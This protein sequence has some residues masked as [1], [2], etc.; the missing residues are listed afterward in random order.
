[1]DMGKLELFERLRIIVGTT[2]C[3]FFAQTYEP[4]HGWRVFLN[5]YP[6]CLNDRLLFLHGKLSHVNDM[7]GRSHGLRR[8]LNDYP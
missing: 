5:G 1:M 7:L 3:R 6:K 2:Y 4:C 8:A